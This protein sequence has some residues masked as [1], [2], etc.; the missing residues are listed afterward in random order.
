MTTVKKVDGDYLIL[1]ANQTDIIEVRTSVFKTTAPFQ[2]GSFTTSARNALS[3][4]NGQIIYNID[5]NKFQG[6][7][8]G[9]W[10]DLN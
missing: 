2:V 6:Y 5:T 10:V 8:A 1:S 7:A 9:A 3:A 4:Q